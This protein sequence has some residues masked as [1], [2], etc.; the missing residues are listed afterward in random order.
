MQC[1]FKV[2]PDMEICLN[3]N[4]P[5]AN[6]SEPTVIERVYDVRVNLLDHTG[7]LTNCKLQD[8]VVTKLIG[9]KVRGVKLTLH[10]GKNY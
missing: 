1:H 6:G 8:S 4:C 10:I 2:D 5:S 9:L 3:A 7:H